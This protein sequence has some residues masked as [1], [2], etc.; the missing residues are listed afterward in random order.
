MNLIY[1]GADGSAAKALAAEERANKRGAG[2]RHAV[3]FDG[4]AE[5]CDRVTIMSD[6]SKFD[7]E[8]LRAAYGDRV[9]GKAKKEADPGDDLAALR[10]EY[11]RVIGKKPFGGWKADTL[12]QK[13]AAG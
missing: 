5:K 7:A 12:R 11:E 2:V 6:V 8:R 4:I 3:M 13:I 10:A 9:A 1:Y